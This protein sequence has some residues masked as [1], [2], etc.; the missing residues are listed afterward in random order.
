MY[1]LPPNKKTSTATYANGILDNTKKIRGIKDEKLD[2]SAAIVGI[3]IKEDVMFYQISFI[4]NSP[5]NYDIEM[6]RI[7]ISDK[8]KTKRTAIQENELKPLYVAGNAT[9]VK[10]Y[11]NSVI[12]V[13]LDKFTIPDA[14]F[15]TVQIMEQNGGRHL[16]MKIGNNKIMKA[17]PLPDLN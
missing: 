3:Y 17:I 13:A 14:K 5:V 8:K 2:V 4:N 16:K 7:Y 1:N 10:A 9:Q 12:V 6:L 11:S 15:L